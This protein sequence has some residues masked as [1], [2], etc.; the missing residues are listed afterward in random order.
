MRGLIFGIL[1]SF[2]LFSCIGDKCP[3]KTEKFDLKKSYIEVLDFQ[4]CELEKVTYHYIHVTGEFF[5]EAY[6]GGYFHLV[7]NGRIDTLIT[8]DS[9]FDKYRF[10]YEPVGEVSGELEIE[11]WLR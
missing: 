10:N 2:F 3:I 9:Y 1:S 7:G 4:H 6:I 8:A 5:G 11:F